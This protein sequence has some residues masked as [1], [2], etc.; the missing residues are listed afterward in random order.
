MIAKS[1]VGVDH[2][3]LPDAIGAI[4]LILPRSSRYAL[5]SERSMITLVPERIVY[6]FIELPS[7]GGGGVVTTRSW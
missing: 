7:T 5:C 4:R 1:P 3:G 2:P 6:A